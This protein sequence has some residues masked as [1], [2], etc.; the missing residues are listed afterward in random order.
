[1]T[2]SVGQRLASSQDVTGNRLAGADHIFEQERFVAGLLPE[3]CHRNQSEPGSTG[4][5]IR[6]R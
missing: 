5:V 1:M 6:R 3:P 4:R 2:Q